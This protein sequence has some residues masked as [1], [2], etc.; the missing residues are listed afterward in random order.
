MVRWFCFLLE[1]IIDCVR[2]GCIEKRNIDFRLKCKGKKL[3]ITRALLTG[4]K[5]KVLIFI[6]N[7]LLSSMNYY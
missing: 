7:S 4:V 1:R 6:L 5:G 2:E 3:L